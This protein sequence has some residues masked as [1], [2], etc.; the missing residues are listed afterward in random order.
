MYLDLC[1]HCLER[2]PQK[3]LNRPLCI[4][5]YVKPLLTYS[6]PVMSLLTELHLIFKFKSNEYVRKITSCMLMNQVDVKNRKPAV[7]PLRCLSF[8][9]P[10]SL[11]ECARVLAV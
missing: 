3:W 4:E 1:V 9:F 10:L 8:S 7:N 11:C 6:V 5:L 2:P